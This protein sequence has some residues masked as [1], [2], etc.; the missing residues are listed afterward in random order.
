MTSDER[1]VAAEKWIGKRFQRPFRHIE[2]M[3][4]YCEEEMPIIGLGVML[5]VM[6][7]FV[8]FMYCVVWPITLIHRP[9]T[10]RKRKAKAVVKS[11]SEYAA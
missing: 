11:M 4:V 9:L 6:P 2:E 1:R 8:L 5:L 7:V 10:L 3:L